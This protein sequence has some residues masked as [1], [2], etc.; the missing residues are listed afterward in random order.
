LRLGC[1][2]SY[3]LKYFILSSSEPTALVFVLRDFQC[4]DVW[5]L[6]LEVFRSAHKGHALD[7]V[8]R[9]SAVSVE[10]SEVLLISECKQGV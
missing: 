7:F 8:Y 1:R 4:T 2:Y 3:E 6:R 5:L 10:L 9:L